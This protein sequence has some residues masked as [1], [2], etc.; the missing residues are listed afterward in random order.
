[1]NSPTFLHCAVI[2]LAHVKLIGRDVERAVIC[3]LHAL[4]RLPFSKMKGAKIH[5]NRSPGAYQHTPLGQPSEGAIT[6]KNG[7]SSTHARY[8]CFL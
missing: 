1:M 5:F 2:I 3:V 6:G 8:R 4:V 7:Y